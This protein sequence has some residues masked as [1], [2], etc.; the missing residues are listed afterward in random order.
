MASIRRVAK[1]L[2]QRI[3][4][5]FERFGEHELANHA[6]A[7]AYAF[8]LSAMPVL[9]LALGLASALLRARPEALADAE[10][11]AVGFLGPMAS[12]GAIEAFI[13]QP[14]GS[15]AAAIGALSLL[16]S[17]RLLVVA[18][19]RGLRVVRGK[20]GK[21]GLVRTNLLG[22]MLELVALLAVVA[23]LAAAEATRILSGALGPQAGLLLDGALRFASR[24][25]PPAVLLA[26]VYLSYRFGSPDRPPRSLA[27]AAALLCV[28]GMIAC[29]SLLGLFMGT[30]RYN[31][32]Y[33]IFGNLV[34][35]LANV[36]LFFCLFFFFAE[37]VYVEE[38]LDALLFARL[39]RDLRSR[40]SG[41]LERA[42]F[43]APER[44]VRRYGRNYGRDEKVFSVGEG[45]E[46]AYFVRRGSIGIYMPS[47]KG[48][49]KLATIEA[50]EIFGE[51]ALLQGEARSATARADEDSELLV[52]PKRLFEAFLD[53]DGG[54]QL[55]LLELLSDRLRKA[56]DRRSLN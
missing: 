39:Q 35:L 43:A 40:P 47:A 42:L 5:S 56:N 44:L 23:V 30:A 54:A 32:L 11:A 37:L 27:V 53:S 2:G 20:S 16:Y 19:Q 18:I 3:I 4:F 1:A 9:L 28:L 48:E 8:L 14:L 15:L 24:A 13:G 21:G 51:M 22:F 41:A 36:Y 52:I 6:A 46:E 17:A 12:G 29:S 38:K 33:G 26:F 55:R 45:G 7:G 34:L 10:R 49:L 25:A 31:L 50:G